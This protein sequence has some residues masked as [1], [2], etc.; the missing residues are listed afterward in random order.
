MTD[1]DNRVLQHRAYVVSELADTC[2]TVVPLPFDEWL[3]VVE[4]I[5]ARQIQ[6]GD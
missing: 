4:R 5:E 1:H 3:E 2:T 6:G